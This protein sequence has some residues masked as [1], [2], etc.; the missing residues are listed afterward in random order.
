MKKLLTFFPVLVAGLLFTSCNKPEPNYFSGEWRSEYNY[1]YDD[2]P[3]FYLTFY[4]QPS[5]EYGDFSCTLSLKDLASNVGVSF[6]GTYF[7]DGD[8]SCVVTFEIDGQIGKY[9]VIIDDDERLHFFCSDLVIGHEDITF[10][11]VD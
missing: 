6:P 5:E 9:N 3:K 10:S 7:N 2:S 1:H 8:K 11:K 4:F